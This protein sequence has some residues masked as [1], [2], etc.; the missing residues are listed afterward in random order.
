MNLRIEFLKILIGKNKISI[1]GKRR[2]KVLV[3]E[4]KRLVKLISQILASLKQ[5]SLLE[6]SLLGVIQIMIPEGVTHLAVSLYIVP[7]KT[8]LINYVQTF[9]NDFFLGNIFKS[10]GILYTPISSLFPA[11]IPR[12]YLNRCEQTIN[13]RWLECF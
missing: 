1:Q 4:F 13:L 9:Q 5:T 10:F 8:V 6:I 2:C 12:C 11:H 7:K 3:R